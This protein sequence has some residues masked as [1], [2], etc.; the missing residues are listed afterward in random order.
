MHNFLMKYECGFF[1]CK[2]LKINIC[3]VIGMFYSSVLNTLLTSLI[4][5][6]MIHI[7]KIREDFLF[8]TTADTICRS[9]H[10]F[11]VV[12]FFVLHQTNTH[13]L[14]F[15]IGPVVACFY[16]LNNI[17]IVNCIYYEHVATKK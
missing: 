4:L 11:F 2:P 5:S 15:D 8:T 10:Y 17:D 1:F 12:F 6:I 9:C 14:S 13:S 3:L 16:I 7:C